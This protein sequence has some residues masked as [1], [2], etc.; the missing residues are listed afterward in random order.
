MRDEEADSYYSSDVS[1][2]SVSRGETSDDDYSP[3]KKEL[4]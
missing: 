3:S 2:T 4:V 1:F